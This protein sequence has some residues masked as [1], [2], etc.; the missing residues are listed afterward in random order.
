MQDKIQFPSINGFYA[1]TQLNFEI[2][3]KLKIGPSL[4]RSVDTHLSCLDDFFV[5]A[6]QCSAAEFGKYFF[7]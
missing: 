3:E 6:V 7:L 5:P 2:I 4:D 1:S